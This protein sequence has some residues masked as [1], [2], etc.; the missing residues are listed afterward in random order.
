MVTFRGEQMTKKKKVVKKRQ[1]KIVHKDFMELHYVI[2][3]DACSR[4][5]WTDKETLIEWAK[6]TA[7]EAHTVGWLVYENKSYILLALSWGGFEYNN[8]SDVIKIPKRWIAKR[9]LI[10]RVKVPKYI[11]M[12]D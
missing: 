9:I 7:W 5:M 8:Y 3:T 2:W 12:T 11:S 6:S 4:T 10:K 1:P